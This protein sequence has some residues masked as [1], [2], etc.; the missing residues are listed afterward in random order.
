MIEIVG[1]K[2]LCQVRKFYIENVVPS[3]S[4]LRC[5]FCERCRTLLLKVDKGEQSLDTLPDPF[6]FSKVSLQSPSTRAN[7]SPVCTCVMCDIARETPISLGQGFKQPQ[8]PR[9]RP[10]HPRREGTCSLASPRPIT[11][12]KRCFQ[13]VGKGINHPKP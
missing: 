5:A 1:E 4:R 2:I 8:F 11:V 13:P 6:N 9:G 3:D 7:P 12:C 10:S